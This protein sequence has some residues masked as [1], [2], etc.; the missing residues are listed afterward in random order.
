ME[1]QPSGIV[2]FIVNRR[3]RKDRVEAFEAVN[4]ELHSIVENAPGYLGT[5][6]IRT[7][8]ETHVEYTVII[9][10]DS[11]ANLKSWSQSP[12]RNEYVNRLQSLSDL[13][14][15]KLETGLEYW[16]TIEK[17]ETP[18]PPRYKMAAVT[19]LVIYP[20]VLIV[21]WLVSKAIEGWGIPFLVEVLISVLLITGLMTYYLMPLVT[22]T[23]SWWLY[24]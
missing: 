6:I 23:F 22:R 18:S 10:F 24:R 9:R 21:P 12:T 8:G 13:T 2:T 4:R 3:V 5:N 16:F 17:D 20:L 7:D 15:E 14:S 19:M 1:S 11:Y